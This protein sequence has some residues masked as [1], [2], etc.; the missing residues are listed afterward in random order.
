M[1]TPRRGGNTAP[2]LVGSVALM[3]GRS[4]TYNFQ[5][6]QR[7]GD[8]NM[9]TVEL[10]IK[11]K[12]GV[13]AGKCRACTFT[14]PD[15]VE[16][17]TARTSQG[18]AFAFAVFVPAALIFLTGSFRSG[19]GEAITWLFG[20]FLFVLAA[21]VQQL[22]YASRFRLAFKSADGLSFRIINAQPS[23]RLFPFSTRT[24]S[25]FLV[26]AEGTGISAEF[27]LPRKGEQGV[28]A[29]VF[30]TTAF[31]G[32]TRSPIH[33]R[34]STKPQRIDFKD[35]AGCTAAFVK[36]GD[37]TYRLVYDKEFQHEWLLLVVAAT[38][39]LR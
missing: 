12:A 29:R 23:T 15:G 20:T 33:S 31:T 2:P 34:A 37:N 10:T 19:W 24:P 28:V 32:Q 5:D 27:K 36:R 11:C 17:A 14:G 7:A 13:L 25:S 30:G 18:G 26:E 8:V 1:A 39:L 16:L 3:A 21:C 9:A 6:A 35:Q 22:F 38:V 4:L